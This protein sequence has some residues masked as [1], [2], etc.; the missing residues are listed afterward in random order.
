MD[1]IC[2]RLKKLRKDIGLN[3][4]SLAEYLGIDQS[5]LS[6]IELGHR[7]LTLSI[8]DK[9][10]ALYACDMDYILCKN[11]NYTP[12]KVAFRS[13][14]L[15]IEDLGGL[16]SI[17][18]LFK[19]MTYLKSNK[20]INEANHLVSDNIELSENVNDLYLNSLAVELRREWELSSYGSINLFST[21]LS[22]IP[23]LTILFY[24]MSENTSG[25]CIKKDN[26]KIIAINS[27]MTKGRQRFTLAHELYHLYFQKNFNNLYI[28]KDSNGSEKEEE[29][30]NTFASFL[31]M[32]DQALKRYRKTNHIQVWDLNKVIGAEQYFQIS[33]KAILYRLKNN[34]FINEEE[35]DSLKTV[36]ITQEAKKRGYSD[37]LYCC[38]TKNEQYLVLGNYIRMIEENN[39]S[40]K[41]SESKKRE[42]L[43]DGFRGDLVFSFSED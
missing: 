43:L 42:L 11:D 28:C 20:N 30:A 32:P 6:Q 9:L 5:Y 40:N 39:N 22:K 26:S 16:A 31:L 24:P 14:N 4:E 19:N 38:T 8:L 18:K 13:K 29:E 1:N 21:V 36:Q 37:E 10:C 34:N 7:K 35:H 15:S 17:N 27:S 41:L 33:H 3:Q 23:D 25:M 12:L 2:E